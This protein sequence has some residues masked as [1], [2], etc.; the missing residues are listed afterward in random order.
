MELNLNQNITINDGYT[1]PKYMLF[2]DVK[3]NHYLCQKL[4]FIFEILFCV[5][6]WILAG[7]MFSEEH[8]EGIVVLFLVFCFS[9]TIIVLLAFARVLRDHHFKNVG[10]IR[11]DIY[12]SYMTIDKYPFMKVKIV[13]IIRMAISVWF[14]SVFYTS[15][16]T[17]SQYQCNIFKIGTLFSILIS[18]AT[19]IYFGTTCKYT[20]ILSADNISRTI[21]PRPVLTETKTEILFEVKE[22]LN[23]NEPIQI[24]KEIINK[25]GKLECNI[26]LEELADNT[27]AR[28]LNCDHYFHQNCIE[29][30]LTNKYSCPNCNQNVIHAVSHFKEPNEGFSTDNNSINYDLVKNCDDAEITKIAD[31]V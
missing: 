6:C 31:I 18:F 27:S 10:R 26:C 25:F 2:V 17:F 14:C 1:R 24:T 30:W 11:N 16:Q 8:D 15:C 5:L 21:I 19:N 23:N 3:P 7:T 12:E 20:Y 13:Y 29:T 22:Y 4:E 28:R 9:N